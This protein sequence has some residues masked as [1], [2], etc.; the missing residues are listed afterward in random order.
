MNE[1]LF[2]CFEKYKEC[3]DIAIYYKNNNITYADFYENI[4]KLATFLE[5]L[6]INKGNIVTLVLPN[7]TQC[8]YLFYDINI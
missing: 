7:N 1:N 3:N 2:Y 8:I 5:R 6:G 4:L